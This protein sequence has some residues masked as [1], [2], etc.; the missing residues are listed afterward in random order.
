MT[1]T[2][3]ILGSTGSIGRQTLDVVRHL[4]VRVATLTAGT[5]VERM[6]EQA[7][8]F[9]PRLISMATKE[10]AEALR[11]LLPDPAPEILW[12]EEGLLAAAEA[13]EADT[14]ITAVVGMV[15]L[16]PTLAALRPGN[17]IGFYRVIRE[18]GKR[19]AVFPL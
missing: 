14:V 18:N 5:N 9:R 1:K 4:P 11:A 3:S 2:I 15:G 8:E 19:P 6:A 17:L 16:R 7:A 10:A 12:G 13:E